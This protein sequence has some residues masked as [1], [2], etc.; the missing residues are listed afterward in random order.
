MS[1]RFV[2]LLD[3]LRTSYDLLYAIIG[4]TDGQIIAVS[5]DQDALPWTGL[6]T[7]LFGD[8]EAIS[9]LNYSL[10]G[11]LLPQ[12]FS[13]GDLFCFVHKPHEAYV[14]G[15][16]GRGHVAVVERYVLGK[17]IAAALEVAWNATE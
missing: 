6:T 1:T 5:G 2:Q 8:P 3:T 14:V 12:A 10:T 13:Q 15:L 11:Q 16:F 9:R 4:S 17:Q 7:S